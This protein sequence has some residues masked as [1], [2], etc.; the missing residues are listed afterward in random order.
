VPGV[1]GVVKRPGRVTVRAV[2]RDGNG[3]TVEGSGMLAKALCH[4]I[5]HLDGVLF[6]DIAEEITSAEAPPDGDDSYEGDE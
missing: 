6:T 5:D 3:I 2:D 4:E 1:S